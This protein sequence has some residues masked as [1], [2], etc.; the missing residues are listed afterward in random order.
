MR[1]LTRC[2]SAVLCFGHACKVSLIAISLNQKR[3]LSVLG[4]ALHLERAQRVITIY[5]VGCQKYPK[6]HVFGQERSSRLPRLSI[7][8]YM[9]CHNGPLS[10]HAVLKMVLK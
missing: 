2:R 9:G 5:L 3:L 4:P 7:A 8:L 10:F 1:T 6:V